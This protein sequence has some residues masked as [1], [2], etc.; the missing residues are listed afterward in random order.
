M[1]TLQMRSPRINLMMTR[2]ARRTRR[3]MTRGRGRK[4]M[5]RRRPT[6][7][8]EGPKPKRSPRRSR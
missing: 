4:V 7:R 5:R 3:K 1:K 6:Q 2:M 8:P